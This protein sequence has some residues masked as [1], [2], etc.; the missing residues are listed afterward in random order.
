MKLSIVIP[1]YNGKNILARNLPFVVQ[2]LDYWSEGQKRLGEIIIV[3][4]AS[5]DGTVKWLNE[6]FPRI[7]VIR[8]KK[9]LR[10]GESCNRGI[11]K[12]EGQIVLLL[13]NDACPEKDFLK[14][15]ADDFE[16]P[17]VFAV[18]CREKNI[19]NGKV[20]DG[21]RGVSAFKKGLMI[22]WRPEDQNEKT[23]TWV[24]GGSAAFRREIWLQLGGFDNIF[25][26]AYEED[27]DICWQALKAGYKII[28]EPK[29]IVTHRHETTNRTVFGAKK[30]RLFSFRNQMI[31]VWKNISD[32]ILLI[33][34]CF[35]LP[36]HLVITGI[37]TDGEFDL[38]F[39]MAL[40]KLPEALISRLKISRKWRIKDK[41]IL[42]NEE[43]K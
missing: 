31:F 14:W 6:D 27:R 29:A 37:K 24:S 10:F 22:H 32:P 20:L 30:I 33:Q 17:K 34:H 2:A 4:D 18:G 9:N 36:Y 39:L 41:K 23:A 12:S 40:C 25:Y 16:D 1:S 43:K 11:K 21:G 28:F 8:N 19:E 26:P 7:K 38:A 3:D 15:I 5:N 35:W 42:E 13:N